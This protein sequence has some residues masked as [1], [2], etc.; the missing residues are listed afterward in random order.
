M[1]VHFAAVAVV[2]RSFAERQ[3]AGFA[4]AVDSWFVAVVANSYIGLHIAASAELF[5]GWPTDFAA[6]VDLDIPEQEAGWDILGPQV[7]WD[8]PVHF[9]VVQ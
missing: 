5:Q 7:G 9:V 3:T 1:A 6:G 8:I 2:P 4:E